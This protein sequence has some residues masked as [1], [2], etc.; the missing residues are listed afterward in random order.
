M[1]LFLSFSF[2]HLSLGSSPPLPSPRLY[3]VLAEE[4]HLSQA[5]S[6]FE[7]VKTATAGASS[8]SS[9]SSTGAVSTDG[10]SSKGDSSSY[11]HVDHAL[12][13][14]GAAEAAQ[15]GSAGMTLPD[16][17]VNLGHLLVIEERYERRLC[18]DNAFVCQLLCC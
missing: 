7:R 6:I 1:I 18:V 9:S 12:A 14:A 11:H 4:G 16:A 17:T 3:Q 10:S 8:S 2:G 5:K 15:G 13:A